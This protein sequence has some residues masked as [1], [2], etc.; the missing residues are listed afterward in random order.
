MIGAQS[1]SQLPV[2]P[3]LQVQKLRAVKQ[4]Y[5][6][7]QENESYESIL[8]PVLL[9]TEIPLNQE[10]EDFI[11]EA[12][13]VCSEII[14]GNDDRL[15]VVVGPCSIHDTQQALE[16]AHKLKSSLHLFPD[17]VVLMR[18]YFEKPRTT[19]GWK[20]LIN[21]PNLDG[22]CMINKG[23]Y[24][25]RKLLHDLT[26]LGLPLA[27]E[28]L[29]TISPQYLSDFITW[30][31]IGARTTESQLHR[32]LASGS[33]HPVGFKNG[34]DGGVGVAVDAMKAASSAHSFI[35]VNE[36]GSAS[37]VKT[38][39]NKNVHVI[40]R[41]GK[42]GPNFA[43]SFVA[44]TSKVLLKQRSGSHPAIMIDCSHGNS[45]KD[46][47]N[48]PKVVEDICAQLRDGNST[49]SGVMI[50]SNIN[51][52]RQDIPSEGPA[53]L[54]HGVSVTD[55]CIDFQTTVRTLKSLQSA[56][57]ERRKIRKQ[58]ENNGMEALLKSHNSQKLNGFLI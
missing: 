48:Q 44:E 3:L 6:R 13:K 53:G 36:E 4:A 23:L 40:L 45:Q 58:D 22:T 8:S 25:A 37:I 39:G 50:E 10:S 26:E 42:H 24:M 38:E 28:L 20:G 19:V 9:R 7:I 52:G 16:Y 49:I 35:G 12:R 51:E 27:V 55:A 57:V 56:V 31:A 33:K 43:K 34:T 30:G 29:D 5:G 32:E 41:G 17:L 18:A 15:I 14:S 47:R 21:D 1:Y 2:S 46:H 54:K 11:Q